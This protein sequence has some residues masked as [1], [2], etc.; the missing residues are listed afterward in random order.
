MTPS[1][2]PCVCLV[3]RPTQENMDSVGN[4]CNVLN[5]TVE[6]VINDLNIG[7]THKLVMRL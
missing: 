6:L 5:Q 4:V 7:C 1:N 3:L 2:V